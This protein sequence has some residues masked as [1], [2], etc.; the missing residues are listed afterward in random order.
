MNTAAALLVSLLL[1]TYVSCAG[2]PCTATLVNFDSVVSSPQTLTGD[3]AAGT[4]FTGS[5]YTNRLSQFYVLISTQ[6][7]TITVDTCTGTAWDS[8]LGAYKEDLCGNV[9][10][11][12]V[13][14][15]SGDN[16]CESQSKMQFFVDAGYTYYVQLVRASGSTGSV[17]YNLK[18]SY[19]APDG[20][21]P[22]TA[23]NVPFG[24]FASSLYTLSPTV[25]AGR[26]YAAKSLSSTLTY[27]SLLLSSMKNPIAEM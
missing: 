13:C 2:T 12:S 21:K 24:N 1:I 15:S 17:T 10:S 7:G 27:R 14:I 22:C 6:D 8:A 4:T 20:H 9:G 23:I 11:T 16:N 3:L 18:F 5:C 25:A 19:T 26:P